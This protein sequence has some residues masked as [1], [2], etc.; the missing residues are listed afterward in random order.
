M[1]IKKMAEQTSLCRL[2]YGS[3]RIVFSLLLLQLRLRS[4]LCDLLSFGSAFEDPAKITLL[5]IH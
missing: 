3:F 4:A 1:G 2:F 5:V